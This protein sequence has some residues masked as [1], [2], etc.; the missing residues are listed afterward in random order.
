MGRRLRKTA[1]ISLWV[2]AGL[3]LLIVLVIGGA[4][5][6]MHTDWGRERIRQ[7]VEARLGDALTGEVSVGRVSGSVLGDF[8]VEDVVIRPPEGVEGA[9]A[10]RI[11]RIEI[12]HNPR[13]LLSRT[14]HAQALRLEG[15]HITANLGP[16]GE[17]DLAKLLRPEDPQQPE[18]KPW[19]VYI[20]EL[21]IADSSFT[22]HR[23]D[24]DPVQ[25]RDLEAAASLKVEGDE[26][27]VD[28]DRATGRWVEEDLTVA[29]DGWI[30]KNA[31][32]LTLDGL[33]VAAA[34]S[35]VTV[36]VAQLDLTTNTGRGRVELEA[37]AGDLRRLM[38][39]TD[40][41]ADV[42]L[43]AAFA[44]PEPDAPWKLTAD[45]TLAGQPIGLSAAVRPDGSSAELS[46][47]AENFDPSAVLATAPPGKLDLKA[48]GTLSGESIK[49]LD[50][51]I[52]ATLSGRVS[53]RQI[54][55]GWLSATLDDGIAD[56]E[57]RG[58]GPVGKVRATAKVD[59]TQS[60][61]VL[62]SDIEVQLDDL[63]ELIPGGELL[64]GSARIE[65][66]VTGDITGEDDLRAT[67]AAVSPRLAFRDFVARDVR[68][69]FD[70][71]NLPGSPTGHVELSADY[72][73][74]GGT[75]IGPLQLVADVTENGRHIEA[76][77]DVGEPRGVYA[78]TG[79]VVADRTGGTF[80]IRAPELAVRTRDLVW[81][82]SDARIEYR[83]DGVIVI[84][85]LGVESQAGQ[86]AVEGRLVTGGE[87]LGGLLEVAVD[88]LELGRVASAVTGE[89]P[90][91]RGTAE[92]TA[93][94]DLARGPLEATGRVRDLRVRDDVPPMDVRLELRERERILDL[95]VTADA[96]DT[97]SAQVHLVTRSPRY[98]MNF[99]EWT[100]LEASEVR[101]LEVDLRSIDAR[102][103]T[104]LLDLEQ[105]TDGQIDGEIRAG[106]GLDP[107]TATI[108]TAG[109]EVPRLRDPV[110]ASIEARSSGDRLAIEA[111]VD[112]QR[113]GAV[114]A[115]A[116]LTL[117]DQP[118]DLTAWTRSGID[119]V[120]SASLTA[121]NLDVDRLRRLVDDPP[122]IA[123]SVD[124]DLVAREK[125]Q[126]LDLST[127]VRGLRVPGLNR[128]LDLA[129]SA[130]LDDGETEAQVWAALGEQPL[131]EADV[132]L[133]AGT[134]ALLR[135]RD[136]GAFTTAPIDGTIAIPGLPLALL[137]EQLGADIP[138]RGELLAT[139]QVDGTIEAPIVQLDARARGAAIDNL[140]FERFA[141]TGRYEQGD[142]R[143]AVD[144]RQQNGGSLALTARGDISGAESARANL[145]ARDFR[146][147]FLNPFIAELDLPVTTV[148]GALDG[149]I[150]ASLSGQ[151]QGWLRLTGGHVAMR[152]SLRPLRD[153]TLDMAIY[154]GIAGFRL[155]AES[156]RG[157]IAASGQ[158]RFQ[159]LAP[160]G[161]QSTVTVDELPFVAGATPVSI[162]AAARLE[163]DR[164]GDLWR[165]S[166]VVDD[167]LV[168]LPEAAGRGELFETGELEDVVFVD[169]IR[170]Q[171]REEQA[172]SPTV[173]RLAIETPDGV[174]VRS[175]EVDVLVAT[176]MTVTVVNG[177]MSINGSASVVRGR[178]TIFDRRYEVIT[179]NASFAGEMPP[180][181]RLNV[182]LAHSFPE[183]TVFIVVGGTLEQP[184]IEF[185]S[186]PPIY[187][188][189]QLLGF[190]LGGRPG[191]QGDGSLTD[192][193][194]GVLTG[195]VS[196]QVE[197]VLK[198]TF[199]I[200]YLRIG[201]EETDTAYVTVGKWL[202]DDLFVA[203]RRNFDAEIDENANEAQLEY[204]LFR[205]WIL[206]SR[207]GDRGIGSADLLWTRRF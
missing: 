21:E 41:R 11:D 152:E 173:I 140:V 112:A 165:I 188:Q 171:P 143:A 72:L 26:L 118:L 155:V 174:V 83:E 71:R 73:S 40:W 160:A 36:P 133:G 92:L 32:I 198:Q 30:G 42:T 16:D 56:L 107:I 167:A 93:R 39:D 46:V 65:A 54:D 44:H 102:R 120:E 170:N 78:A 126:E 163:G 177:E 123:G 84:D 75:L 109:L 96:G 194:A 130:Q 31:D 60:I 62:E 156:G 183:A 114:S 145:A 138:F 2:L 122:E 79:S 148:G 153:L 106:E 151:P 144:A 81:E 24:A 189:A 172:A 202:S 61:K 199:P 196:S 63:G 97:G 18:P 154:R 47:S 52:E 178:V 22:L 103:I 142:W 58:T 74:R 131:L 12:D 117:P 119:A 180:N 147:G 127:S 193:T 205:N 15:V 164:E 68:I 182:R 55:Q 104:A 37:T 146:I 8:A 76:R 9:E 70:T 35:R 43:E 86:L 94:L 50:G 29:I 90:P 135:D 105:I 134:R 69:A 49:T 57:V 89:P 115:K 5:I 100:D 158:A 6:A 82:A 20:H 4:L 17:L 113:Q 168:R 87:R 13:S 169:E 95:M 19:N 157:D 98:M 101:S 207:L 179:A 45:G 99:D 59:F 91:L 48:A 137:G 185:D 27:V 203:Y 1:R 136:P 64:E 33:T 186:D 34:D 166:T 14:F 141:I 176:D 191:A 10:I 116:E 206:E 192:K 88:S 77:F 128:A 111:L 38:P 184:E 85:R 159:G 23:P 195:L 181:P 150:E 149:Q 162:T 7:Q 53:Q 161:F 51:S 110:F 125:S 25:V 108:R 66:E 121:R 204:Q 197:G 67:G 187:D 201:T 132:A 80:E 139:A 124:L 28:L 129:V 175:E 190:V 3:G 200:D